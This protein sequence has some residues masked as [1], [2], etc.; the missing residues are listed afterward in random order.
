[1]LLYPNPAHETLQLQTTSPVTSIKITDINGKTVKELN[2]NKSNSINQIN[3]EALKQG[4]YIIEANN[5]S[6]K[7]TQK[8]IKK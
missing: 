1:V 3:I 4:I 2:L 5:G 8:F 6:E 7:F